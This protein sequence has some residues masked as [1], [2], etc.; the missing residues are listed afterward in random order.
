VGVTTIRHGRRRRVLVCLPNASLGRASVTMLCGKE[1]A[2]RAPSVCPGETIP[3]DTEPARLRP[4]R[5]LV[6]VPARAATQA[7]A[8]PVT[9]AHTPAALEDAA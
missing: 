5:H 8:M 6:H 3:A 2:R 7:H 1:L 9:D 4:L